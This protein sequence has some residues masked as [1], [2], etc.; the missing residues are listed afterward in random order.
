MKLVLKGVSVDIKG[1]E[2]VGVIGRTGSGK[3]TP[4]L[5]SCILWNWQAVAFPSMELI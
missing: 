5:R 4:I 3:S 1:G 2:M